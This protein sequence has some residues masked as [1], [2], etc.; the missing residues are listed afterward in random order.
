MPKLVAIA[1]KTIKRGPMNEVLCAN[2]TQH[3]G[4]EK[5]VFGRPGKRQVTV[6]SL[7]QWQIACQSIG[8]NLPWTTRRANLLVDGLTFSPA[9]VGKQLLIGDLCLEVTGETD[10]CKKMDQA[11]AGLESALTPDWRGGV[12]CRVINDAMIHI[13]DPV[14]LN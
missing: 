14:T 13:G 10:P 9:D 8:A 6:L 4:I 11:H 2:V 12:T 3:S 5:D 7:Q 1:Y